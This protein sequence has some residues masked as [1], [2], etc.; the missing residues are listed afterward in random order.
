M[1]VIPS[2]VAVDG[3]ESIDPVLQRFVEEPL[4]AAEIAESFFADRT[5]ERDRAW[6]GHAGLV[7]G[8][9]HGDEI[10]ETAAVVADS[11]SAQERS[12]DAGR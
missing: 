6:R 12:P 3:D 2:P 8:A 10:G 4:D 7:Q 5:D 1:C 9:G 11:W